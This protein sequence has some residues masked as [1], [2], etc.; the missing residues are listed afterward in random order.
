MPKSLAR[1]RRVELAGF[2]LVAGARRY[3]MKIAPLHRLP[4]ADARFSVTS[5]HAGQHCN[6]SRFDVFFRDLGMPRPDVTLDIDSGSLSCRR[7]NPGRDGDPRDFLHGREF[8]W[9]LI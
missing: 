4:S 7:L 8:F 1:L 2:F 6:Q 3:F 5:V 9:R